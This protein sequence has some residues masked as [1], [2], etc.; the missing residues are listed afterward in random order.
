MSRAAGRAVLTAALLVLLAGCSDEPSDVEQYEQGYRFGR[1][2]IP[3][4]HV[5]HVTDPAD[6]VHAESEC[7]EHAE[8]DG[9]EPFPPTDA[10]RKGC[11]HGA[12]GLPPS[13][14]SP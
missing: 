12:S 4:G 7:A 3:D 9:V 10:W 11:T 6:A 14:P 2:E 8:T 5:E 13:P 1:D